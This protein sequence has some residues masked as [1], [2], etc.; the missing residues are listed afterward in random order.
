MKKEDFNQEVKIEKNG[1]IK[2]NNTEQWKSIILNT[3]IKR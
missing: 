3:R 1:P 2:I